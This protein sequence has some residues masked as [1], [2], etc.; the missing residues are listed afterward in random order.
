MANTIITPTWVSKDTAMFWK[1]HIRAVGN[2]AKRGYGKEWQN[3]PE[4]AKIG[5]TVQ[6]RVP[7]AP[8][9]SEG[10]ALQIQPYIN[11]TVPISLTHQL[12]VACGW[13]TADDTVEIEEVQDR[14]TMPSGKA[15]G[16]K[17]DVLF[18]QEIYKQIYMTIGTPGVPIT[19]NAVYTD[20]VAR[21]ANVSAQ[22]GLEAVL[23]PK[24]MSKLVSA[25]FAI[26]NLP[27]GTKMWKSGQF[28]GENFG[29]DEW[30]NDPFMPTHT[31]GTFTASTPVV[32]GASQTGSTLTISGMGTYSLKAGD[33]FK[34]AGLDSV[35][36][37]AKNDTGDLAE[38]TLSVDVA[39]SSTAT[40]T[41]TPAIITSGPLQT[42]TGSP[43][44]SAAITFTGA[45]GTV[46]AT[47]ATTTSRQSIIANPSAFAFVNAPLARKLAGAET[48]Q[49]RDADAKVSMRYVEQYNIQT[50]Q[51]PRRIDMLVGNAVVQ[52]YYAMRAWS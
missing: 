43:A 24:A 39:G 4:G 50:D 48:G 7:T 44:N 15:L 12:Q 9:V 29:V 33:T 36:P 46:G 2:L 8:I 31:T 5:Y 26:F 35:N 18:A 16:A 21:M 6:Q 40:L 32:S 17:C 52:A 37:V 28:S 13:S 27:N 20:G 30:F 1:S 47:M 22:D 14:W 38:F 3:L 25:N 45:T 41:F 49:I 10:Q 23:D 51:E 11:Q 34:I 42:V 19:D